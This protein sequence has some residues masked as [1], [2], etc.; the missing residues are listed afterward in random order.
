MK[1]SLSTK[2][3]RV[4][5]SMQGADRRLGQLSVFEFSST[6]SH[7]LHRIQLP[8]SLPTH[9]TFPCRQNETYSKKCPTL[10]NLSTASF[11]TLS[12]LMA[13]CTQAEGF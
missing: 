11:N 7:A 2:F 1:Y 8:S 3:L 9:W 12:Q 4:L 10:V 5:P 13:Q 6:T